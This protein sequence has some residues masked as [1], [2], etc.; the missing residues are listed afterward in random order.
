MSWSWSHT[1]EA[2]ENARANLGRKPIKDLIV[3]LAEWKSRG[4]DSETGEQI[5]D[6]L[7][8]QKYNLVVKNLTDAIAQGNLTK[9]DIADEIWPLMEE[10]AT[11]T[12]GGWEAHCCPF[13][14]SAHMVSFDPP[15]PDYD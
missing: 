8:S 6:E 11:C 2:Y 7:D 1:A 4:F 13:E 12:N 10:Q 3:I 15:E 14:C 5:D 9:E